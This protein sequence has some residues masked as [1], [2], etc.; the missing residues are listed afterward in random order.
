VHRFRRGR[1]LH[2]SRARTKIRLGR[3]GRLWHKPLK[4]ETRKEVYKAGRPVHPT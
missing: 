4:G 1:V 2:T 3:G